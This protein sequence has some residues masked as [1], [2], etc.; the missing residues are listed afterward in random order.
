M[1]LSVSVILV[2]N[3]HSDGSFHSPDAVGYLVVTVCENAKDSIYMYCATERL[4]THCLEKYR[5]YTC[6]WEERRANRTG[7]GSEKGKK[8]EGERMEG[9]MMW[10]KVGYVI[11]KMNESRMCN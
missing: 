1:S 11:N 2:R 6:S 8:G 7:V 10:M 9:E 3:V 5:Y 4:P